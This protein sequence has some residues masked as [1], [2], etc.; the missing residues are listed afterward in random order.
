MSK[1]TCK[2]EGDDV[3]IID[4]AE[5]ETTNEKREREE[6]KTKPTDR[7]RACW[8]GTSED[9]GAAMTT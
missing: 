4:D 3:K 9:P 7:G 2:T 1:R 8:K 5:R 6:E